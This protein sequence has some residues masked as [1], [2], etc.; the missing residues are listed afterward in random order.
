MSGTIHIDKL[1]NAAVK[2]GVSDIHITTCLPPV[3]RI[4]GHMRPQKTKVLTADDTNGLMKSITPERCQ[5]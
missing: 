5:I 3:F 2:N 4:D 1:L